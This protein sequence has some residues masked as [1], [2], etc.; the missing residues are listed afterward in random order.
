L[1]SSKIALSL[2]KDAEY[3]NRYNRQSFAHY[4]TLRGYARLENLASLQGRSY[5]RFNVCG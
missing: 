3:R 4:R 1:E 5:R 2:V